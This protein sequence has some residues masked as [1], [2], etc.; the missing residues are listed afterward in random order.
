MRISQ[1]AVP[2]A[3][4]EKVLEKLGMTHYPAADR[5]GLYALYQV[6]SRHIP[7]DNLRR[8]IQLAARPAELSPLIAPERF[9]RDWLS[10]GVGGTCWEFQAALHALLSDCGFTLRYAMSTVQMPGQE[11][12]LYYH[13]TLIA[14]VDDQPLIFDPPLMLGEPLPLKPHSLDHPLWQSGVHF[15]DGSWCITWRPL[16][17]PPVDCRLYHLNASAEEVLDQRETLRH[18]DYSHFFASTLIRALHTDS[19]SGIVKG[20]YIV[21]HADGHETR[22]PLSHSQQQRLLTEEFG[23]SERLAVQVPA[24]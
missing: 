17:R 21:R 7:Y 23:I 24:G 11:G 2:T 13:G 15:S 12:S 5:P 1:P 3:L 4:R 19:I 22:R 9:F 18:L 20:E 16:G 10:D 8:R 14:D 6:C